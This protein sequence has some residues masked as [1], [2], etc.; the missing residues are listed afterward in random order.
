MAIRPH[1]ETHLHQIH[2]RRHVAV[3][4]PGERRLG[5][6]EIIGEGLQDRAEVFAGQRLR[7]G[8]T[9]TG[10]RSSG[11]LTACGGCSPWR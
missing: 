7:I 4:D 1:V 8:L 5:G 2:H 11:T 6:R 10:K 9:G 3:A